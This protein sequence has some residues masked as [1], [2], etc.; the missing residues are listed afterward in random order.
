MDFM[1]DIKDVP[2]IR[3]ER[4]APPLDATRY[5]VRFYWTPYVTAADYWDGEQKRWSKSID[6]F[7]AA[8]DKVKA[9]A[10]DITTGAATP[11]AKARKLY[12]AVQAVENTDFTRA[13]SESE[14][15]VH[16]IR[17]LR[18]AEE[19]GTEERVREPD[20]R[21]L[22][23]SRSRL[24]AGGVRGSGGGSQ[25][26]RFRP[27]FLSLSQLDWLLVLLKLDGKD[28]YL[29]PGQKFCPFGQLRWAHLLSGGLSQ[30]AKGP[31]LHSAQPVEGRNHGPHRGSDA[32]T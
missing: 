21:S 2:A 1:L 32:V 30:A 9:A 26:A 14:R 10:A 16:M 6:E 12:D 25:L 8:T 20:R 4:D 19:C 13:R 5:R 17:E 28:V 22:P 23:G 29:D 7:A 18:K 11:D 24:G 31:T 15:Q 27:N 3:E